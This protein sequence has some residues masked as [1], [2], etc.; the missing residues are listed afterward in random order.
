MVDDIA[1]TDNRIS[2]IH[3]SNQGLSAARNMGI[4]VAKGEYI[5]F[6]DSDDFV[7]QD[8]YKGVMALLNAHPE[9]DILEFSVVEK[10]G[11]KAQRPLILNDCV[12]Q[13]KQEYWLKGQ[14]YRHT[15]AWNKIYRRELF[16]DIE[17]PKGK[18]FEDAHTLP[19][20]MA[21]AEIIAT[22][23][24]GTYYYCRNDAGITANAD[25]QDLTSLLEA[26][27]AYING[28]NEIDSTYYAHVL[29]IQLDVYEAT[30]AVPLLPVRPFYGNLKLTLLHLLGIKRLCKLNKFLH[31]AIK[32]G[33]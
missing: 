32:P 21:A 15:Y 1:R 27:L 3:Q 19:K 6:V 28:N 8:T 14:A 12:Y 4:K 13:N 23:S 22:T 16:T 10:Y 5:T 25:G 30:K 33:R 20:L 9:Y 2:V 18:N 17:F 31:K 11:S 7:A 29:N 26:H 24:L